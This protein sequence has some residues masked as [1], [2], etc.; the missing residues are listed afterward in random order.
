M[1][2]YLGKEDRIYVWMYDSSIHNI[3]C[4]YITYAYI[5]VYNIYIMYVYMHIIYT[6]TH[7]VIRL[8]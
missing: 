5:Y 6:Y 7:I 4:L 3:V 1:Q 8:P 2:K